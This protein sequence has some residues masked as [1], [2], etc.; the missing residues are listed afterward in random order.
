MARR[1]CLVLLFAS[2]GA[3]KKTTKDWSKI[4]FDAVE[5]EWKEGD[6]ADELKSE[7]EFYEEALARRR[8]NAPS[9]PGGIDLEALQ[10][11]SPEAVQAKL[12]HQQSNAG[13]AMI[14]ITL[15]TNQADGTPWDEAA[16][17]KE[18]GLISA[19]MKTGGI[20]LSA[21]RIDPRRLLVTTT[22][23]W[24]GQD[25]I[26]FLLTRET[27]MKVTWDNVDYEN[28]DAVQ[29]DIPDYVKPKAPK[30]KKKKAKKR[31]A[32]L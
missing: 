14:F 13:S 23:G 10:G 15:I 7:H 31:K 20:N 17:N 4:D 2:V 12:A 6:E 8:A 9:G 28:P 26:D 27:V 11:M 22:Y 19:L 30:K 32:D 18:A 21:Y 5:N 24:Y 29:D 16:E 3:V 1:L 25:V